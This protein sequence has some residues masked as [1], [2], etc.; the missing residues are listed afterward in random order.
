LAGY[1]KGHRLGGAGI[2]LNHSL[3]I[4]NYKNASSQDIRSLAEQIIARVEN[5][6]KIKLTPEPK[7]LEHPSFS[8]ISN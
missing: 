6:F 2:S 3:A 1:R 4:V 5:K 8:S 7:F